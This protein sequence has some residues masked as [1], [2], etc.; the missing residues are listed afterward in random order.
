MTAAAA[1]SRQGRPVHAGQDHHYQQAQPGTAEPAQS[2][3]RR[4]P[5]GHTLVPLL[6]LAATRLDFVTFWPGRRAAGMGPSG[7]TRAVGPTTS[8][9]RSPR[10]TAGGAPLPSGRHRPQVDVEGGRRALILQP[11]AIRELTS[12]STFRG[13]SRP[14]TGGVYGL[15]LLGLDLP[16][17]PQHERIPLQPGRRC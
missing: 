5:Y 4:H 10:A 9:C 8:K 11:L 6:K 16:D 15:R 14:R 2:S 7:P 17:L 13:S 1:P 3:S 12:S